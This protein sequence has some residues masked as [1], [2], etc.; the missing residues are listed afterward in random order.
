MYLS[1]WQ[2]TW[3]FDNALSTVQQGFFGENRQFI[4]DTPPLAYV[5]E[6]VNANRYHMKQSLSEANAYIFLQHKLSE[7]FAFYL[8]WNL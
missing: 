7:L 3:Y 5:G 4:N 2:L 1:L 8:L 6:H